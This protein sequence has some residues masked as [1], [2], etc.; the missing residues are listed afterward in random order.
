MGDF[1]LLKKSTL[2]HP[3]AGPAESLAAASICPNPG[4]KAAKTK[5]RRWHKAQRRVLI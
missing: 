2:A 1:F 4:E 5:T 3:S